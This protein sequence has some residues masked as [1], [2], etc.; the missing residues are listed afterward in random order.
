MDVL[1]A[2]RERRSIRSYADSPVEPEKLEKVLEAARLAPSASNR[3]NW[4]FVVVQDKATIARLVEACNGQAFVGQAPVFI[5][6]CATAPGSVMSCGQP[7]DTVDL[8]IATA[9]LILEAYE[10]GLGTCWLGSFNET[11]VKQLLAIPDLVRVVAVTPLGYAAVRPKP[12]TRKTLEQIICFE[13]YQA[14]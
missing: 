7:R 8:S 5:A 1:S 11:K 4:K 12:T 13:T 6:A 3:Q 2:I 9:Y 14:D 10:Q